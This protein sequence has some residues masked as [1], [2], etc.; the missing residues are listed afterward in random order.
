MNM[1][2]EIIVRT[3]TVE[4]AAWEDGA[5]D[6]E[7]ISDSTDSDL[8]EVDR[9]WRVAGQAGR[10]PDQRVALHLRHVLVVG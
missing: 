1:S 8:V 2:R 9:T 6:R 7:Q 10:D 4:Y 3:I 5:D